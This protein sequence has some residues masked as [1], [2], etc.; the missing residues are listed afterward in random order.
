M[1]AFTLSA[2]AVELKELP[3]PPTELLPIDTSAPRIPCDEI[4]PALMK[5][6]DMNRQHEDGVAAF[7]TQAVDK[8]NGWYETLFPLEGQE[9]KIEAGAFEPIRS[10]SEKMSMIV[11]YSYDNTALLAQELDRI[12]VSMRE[13]QH[14]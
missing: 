11:D 14:K 3:E 8:I 10:G 2:Q 5:F 13:C 6:K 7:L 9:K 12:I 4:L 1:C